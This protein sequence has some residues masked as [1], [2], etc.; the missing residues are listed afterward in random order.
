M[1]RGMKGEM[2]WKDDGRGPTWYIGTAW[3]MGGWVAIWRSQLSV[4]HHK[5]VWER[6]GMRL[7]W[8][9]GVQLRR[10]G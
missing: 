7:G 8:R 4:S 5:Q 10:S 6:G 3:Y 2:I 9:G 1:G